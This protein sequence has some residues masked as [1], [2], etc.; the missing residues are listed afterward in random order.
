MK[1]KVI[2]IFSEIAYSFVVF[3]F[4]K[5]LGGGVKDK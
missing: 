5:E 2:F 4:G 3:Q 1:R